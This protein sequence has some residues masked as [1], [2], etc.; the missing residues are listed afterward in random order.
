MVAKEW[1]EIQYLEGKLME[2]CF[3][4]KKNGIESQEG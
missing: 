1:R 4:V 2:T 3:V